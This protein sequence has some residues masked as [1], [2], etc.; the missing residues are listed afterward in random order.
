MT[1]TELYKLLLELCAQPQEG[2]WLEFKLRYVH[3]DEIG[4]YISALSNGATISNKPFG[5]LVWGVENIT[6]EIKGS[7]FSFKNA[8]EGNQ[9]LELWLR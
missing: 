8:K 2:H 9:D 6:H 4:E 7:L 3:H 5:Y 1:Q